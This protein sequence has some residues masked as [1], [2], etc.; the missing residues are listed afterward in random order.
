VGDFDCQERERERE[1]DF[2]CAGDEWAEALAKW[3]VPDLSRRWMSLIRMVLMALRGLSRSQVVP[4]M[5][6]GYCGDLTDAGS[7]GAAGR[8]KQTRSGLVMCDETLGYYSLARFEA[9]VHFD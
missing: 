5:R 7:T 9:H 4:L 6:R 1:S 8:I 3:H 2:V